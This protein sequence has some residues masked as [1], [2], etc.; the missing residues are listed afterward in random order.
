MAYL[1]IFIKFSPPPRYVEDF[2]TR[3]KQGREHLQ[4]A[5]VGANVS[6]LYKKG[7]EENP[8]DCR[9]IALLHTEYK[10]LTE[11]ITGILRRD[12]T[13]W[14]IPPE[15]L[16]RGMY[17]GHHLS[18][19]AR[20][21]NHVSGK[22]ETEQKLFQL[23]RFYK[24]LWFHCPLPT[25]KTNWQ[26][27]PTYEHQERFERRH[28]LMVNTGENWSNHKKTHICEERGTPEGYR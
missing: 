10:I 22:N 28:Q 24:S 5:D 8:S 17:I 12:W 2:V 14:V 26:C 16:A 1:T 4:E 21:G 25:K 13:E 23:V 11:T 3:V 6:M 18:P 19:A 7:D 27:T 9:P 20:Q 15:Q